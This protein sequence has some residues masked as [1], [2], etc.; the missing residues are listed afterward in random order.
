LTPDAENSL[1]P[2]PAGF[3]AHPLAA[4]P[5]LSRRLIRVAL[6]EV[7]DKCLFG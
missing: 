2:D 7:M 3:A 4:H 6:S 5:I 1:L